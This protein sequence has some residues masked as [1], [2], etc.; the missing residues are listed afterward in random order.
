MTKQQVNRAQK[1][2]LIGHFLA[3]AGGAC[4]TIAGVLELLENGQLSTAN[5]FYPSTPE[6]DEQF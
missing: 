2:A 4:F 6:I 1:W 5:P 3:I